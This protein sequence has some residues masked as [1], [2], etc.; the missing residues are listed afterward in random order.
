MKL[1]IGGIGINVYR[2]VYRDGAATATVAQRRRALIGFAGGAFRVADL[3]TA[4]ISTVP[5]STDV[6]LQVD[7]GHVVG[8]QGQ[9]DD[10][11]NAP[12]HIA[13]RTWLLVVRDPNRPDV[14]CRCC[15][16]WSGSPWQPCWAR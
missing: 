1:L 3:A 10:A 2:P 7:R 6:Q 15:W 8:D 9:L 4:A 16:P 13:D 14:A 11:A 5:N 12:I